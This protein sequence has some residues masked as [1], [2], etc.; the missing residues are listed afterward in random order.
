MDFLDIS[1]LGATYQYVIKI[2]KKNKQD[3][4]STNPSQQ[5]HAKDTPNSQNKGKRK[6]GQPQDNQSKP[7]VKKVNEKSRKDTRKWCEFHKIL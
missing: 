7:Q 2:K 5:K 4:S 1:S 3:F 6:D